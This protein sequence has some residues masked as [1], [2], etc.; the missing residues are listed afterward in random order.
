[1]KVTKNKLPKGLSYP[2]SSGL[3]KEALEAQNITT[4]TTLNYSADSQLLVA[5]YYL[6]RPWEDFERLI[7]SSGAV[8]SGVLELAKEYVVKSVVP[9]FVVWA[10]ELINLPANSSKFTGQQFLQ[11]VCPENEF[12]KIATFSVKHVIAD[13]FR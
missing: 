11:W 1:V 4:Q 8:D 9:E 6:R 13:K 12:N 2:L 3:L 7:I 10:N 5:R